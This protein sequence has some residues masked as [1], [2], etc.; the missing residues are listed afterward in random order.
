M[1]WKIS[2]KSLQNISKNEAQQRVEQIRAFEREL[3]H[4][5]DE[6]IITITQ[7][8]KNS[9]KKS[10]D[11]LLNT[12]ISTFDVDSTSHK[13]QL[14][15][16]MKIA[17]FA[18]SL[19]LAFSIFLLFFQFW[20]DLDTNTQVI[21]LIFTPLVLLGITMKLSYIES[22]SYYAKIAALLSFATFILNLSMLGQIFNITPSPNA[23]L[24]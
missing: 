11:N 8:Q 3:L 13:K 21:I 16:G 2:T 12:L 6:N 5:E 17:S 14:S 7:E 10:H 1:R 15:L 9:I 24:V 18:A 22:I 20:G 23:F 4:V 19:G